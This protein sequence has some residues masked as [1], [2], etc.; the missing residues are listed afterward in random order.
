MTRQERKINKA[1]MVLT[2]TGVLQWH[3]REVNSTFG[4][5]AEANLAVR[6]C[7]PTGMDD[8]EGDDRW[9]NLYDTDNALTPIAIDPFFRSNRRLKLKASPSPTRLV[10]VEDGH[11]I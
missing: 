2:E 7:E 8:S 9:F 4:A 1:L 10:S 3:A 5:Y 6:L 11:E